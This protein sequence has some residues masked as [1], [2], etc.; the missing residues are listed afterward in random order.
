MTGTGGHHDAART[1]DS[2]HFGYVPQASLLGVV[3]TRPTPP[4]RS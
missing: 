1:Q 3:L 2:R 4:Y